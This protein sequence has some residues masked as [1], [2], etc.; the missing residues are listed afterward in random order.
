MT[1]LALALHILSAIVWVGGMFAIYM[2]L[3]RALS[4]LAGCPHGCN[5]ANMVAHGFTGLLSTG[6]PKSL[7]AQIG[8]RER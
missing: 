1:I 3:R 2:C 7:F 4:V 5:V 6:Q 8:R